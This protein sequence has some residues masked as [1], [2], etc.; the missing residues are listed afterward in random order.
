MSTPLQV[1]VIENRPGVAD[2]AIAELTDAGHDVHR[3][4]DHGE[5]A[6]PCRGLRGDQPCPLDGPVDVALLVRRGPEP[7]PTEFEVG[8]T[9]ARRGGVPVVEDG[10]GSLDPFASQVAA[11]VCLGVG[12]VQ[13][14]EDAAQAATAPLEL[15][16]EQSLAP[17]LLA[18]DLP[19][20]TVHASA[21]WVGDSLRIRLDSSHHLSTQLRGQMCVAAV[22]RA[23]R[24]ARR[25]RSIEVGCS[26]V[27]PAGST[28]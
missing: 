25:H 20:D 19:S 16:V 14:V 12:V 13:S 6:F 5:G 17:L 11:R 10:A 27:A 3:C 26:V 2:D 15:A 1:L 23:Q 22:A 21:R 18:H 8:V 24:V 7:R 28:Y 4:H 9:C